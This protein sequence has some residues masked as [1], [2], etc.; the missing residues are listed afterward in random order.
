VSDDRGGRPTARRDGDG[1]VSQTL[2]VLGFDLDSV[3]RILLPKA[4][5]T[6]STATSAVAF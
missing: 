5:A 1:D 4:D 3:Q 6:I 2:S